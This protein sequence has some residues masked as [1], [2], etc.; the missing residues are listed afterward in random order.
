MNVENY[1]LYILKYNLRYI[2]YTIFNSNI[3]LIIYNTG[4]KYTIC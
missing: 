1:I 2:I 4:T 3:S